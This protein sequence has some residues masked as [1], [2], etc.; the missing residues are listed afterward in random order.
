MSEDLLAG[1]REALAPH[2]GHARD[3]EIVAKR[4]GLGG[5]R[6]TR[7]EWK[8]LNEALEAWKQCILQAAH[9][10]PGQAYRQ[11]HQQITRFMRLL[12]ASPANLSPQASRS[13]AQWL[14]WVLEQ[15][16]TGTLDRYTDEIKSAVLYGVQG[17]ANP[18]EVASRLYQA[19]QAADRD[20][21]LVAQTE[22][23]RANALG[24]L[25][26]T[27]QMGY[28]EVWIPPHTGSCE[29]CKALIENRIFPV[30]QLARANNYG[31]KRD[32][33]EPALPLHP[34]CRHVATP[35]IPEVYAEAQD[36]YARMRELGLDDDTLAQMFDSSGQLRPQYEGDRRLVAL[37][38]GKVAREPFEHLLGEAVAKVRS[39]GH[40]S[41]GFFDPPQAGLDPLLW[42]E[43]ER[44]KPDVRDA[45]VAFWTGVLGD[46]WERWGRVYVTGSAT[47][48]QWGTGWQHPW[49][50]SHQIQTFPD[51]DTHLVIDYEKVRKARPMWAGMSPMEL[52][53]LLEAWVAKAKVD[54]EV[55]PGMRLDAYIRTETSEQEFE[56][57]IAQ[58]QQGVWDVLAGEWLQPPTHP[59]T[60]QAYGQRILG[61]VGGRLA[62]EHP[63]W[64]GDAEHAA[65][66]LQVLLDAY[67]EQPG[68]ETLTPL[69][70]YMDG[71]YEERSA[72]FLNGEGQEGRG[73]FMWQWLEVFGPL[74]DAKNLLARAGT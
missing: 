16:L 13:T 1:L 56:R 51:V 26:A 41:K 40:V 20:W 59:T 7:D 48:Y 52:R 9:L 57:D 14:R 2:N 12:G 39:T 3:A 29:A 37:F 15:E 67:N 34:R 8:R 31:K 21:R 58:T 53:K 38:A 4:F 28:S 46:G 33:W 54:A 63:D 36:E 44:L 43:R 27:R 22:M 18:T 62:H 19:T 47:S 70:D 65:S 71:L 42:S 6:L 5:K 72:A 11:G 24:R 30:E 74:L 32:A 50:G 25:E 69:Q 10:L 64:L 35:W 49:L 61:G 66:Q 17:D 73:N 45:I 23:A 55:A 68:P 60:G